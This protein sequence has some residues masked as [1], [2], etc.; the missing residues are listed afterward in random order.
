MSGRQQAVLWI[1]LILISFN[2]FVRGQWKVIWTAISTAPGN[3][4]GGTV[5]IPPLPKNGLPGPLTG[6]PD[7]GGLVPAPGGV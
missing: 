4:L 7:N 2:L 1:G 6:T 3:A 5:K